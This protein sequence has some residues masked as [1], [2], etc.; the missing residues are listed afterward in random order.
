[1]LGWEGLIEWR[2]EK[3]IRLFLQICILVLAL[4]LVNHVYLASI[5]NNIKINIYFVFV[6][7][8][9]F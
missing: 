9:V 8:T 2:S 7:Q 5:V 1:M 3:N 4:P 6:C